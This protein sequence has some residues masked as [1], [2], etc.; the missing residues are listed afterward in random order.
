MLRNAIKTNCFSV[1][2]LVDNKWLISRDQSTFS[3][4]DVPE[5]KGHKN[6]HNSTKYIFEREENF[7][8]YFVTPSH[9]FLDLFSIEKRIIFSFLRF[10]FY[11]SINKSVAKLNLNYKI[12]VFQFYG[13]NFKIIALKVY[14]LRL[15]YDFLYFLYRR[16]IR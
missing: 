4:Y 1:S 5:R 9:L 14:D 7:C 15:L 11:F 3:A 12:I 8:S 13:I 16:E 10:F 6:S 2:Y